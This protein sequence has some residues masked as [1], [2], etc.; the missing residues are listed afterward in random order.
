MDKFWIV[1]LVAFV[2][3]TCVI[4]PIAMHHK[5]TVVIPNAIV[6]LAEIQDMTCDE[7]KSRDS[8][9]SYWTP[10]NAK[11]ARGI[12]QDCLDAGL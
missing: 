8:L 12:L 6:E 7:I 10:S 11:F 3:V 1:P 4:F 5:I 9:G 2:L